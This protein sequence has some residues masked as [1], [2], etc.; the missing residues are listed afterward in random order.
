MLFVLHEIKVRGSAIC[1]L[2][3]YSLSASDE[4]QSL[5]GIIPSKFKSKVV[6]GSFR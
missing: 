2:N 4:M 6:F 1:Y 5:I 3:I